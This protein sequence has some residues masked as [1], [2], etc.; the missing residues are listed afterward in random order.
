MPMDK[1]FVKAEIRELAKGNA[2]VLKIVYSYF[3]LYE[4]TEVW[5]YSTMLECQ[6]KLIIERTQGFLTITDKNAQPIKIL[7]EE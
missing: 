4:Y 1:R 7:P 6:N 5:C 2:W 3:S